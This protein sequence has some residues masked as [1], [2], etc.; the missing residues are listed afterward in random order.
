MMGVGKSTIGKKLANKLKVQFVDVD[1]L[2]EKKEKNTIQKIFRGK[3]ENYFRIIEKNITLEILKKE[4]QVIALG[5][6]SFL[7]SAIRN[8]ASKTSMSVWL[9]LNPKIIF[10]RVRDIKKR[11]LLNK[12]NLE[13]SINK[14][15]SSRKKIYSLSNYKVVCDFL[16][17]DQIVNKI[18]RFYE[19]SKNKI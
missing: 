11:P 8:Q 10:N 2:I 5:G 19:I 6:G 17:I 12:E 3:G 13:E 1:S 16:E 4:N 18:I 9:D 15:Y 7:N 14:I